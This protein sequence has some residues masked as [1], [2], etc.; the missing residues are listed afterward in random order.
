MVKDGIRFRKVTCVTAQGGMPFSL[1]YM[2]K[3]RLPREECGKEYPNIPI[4]ECITLTA[5]LA[6]STT[7]LKLEEK[8]LPIYSQ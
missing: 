2:A 6:S 8:P 5:V 4:Q 7:G 3:T 1:H